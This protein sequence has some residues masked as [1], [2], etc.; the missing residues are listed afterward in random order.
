MQK[1]P[2]IDDCFIFVTHAF[3]QCFQIVVLGC[4]EIVGLKQGNHT[5]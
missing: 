5:R 4:I 2:C 3:G 1:N